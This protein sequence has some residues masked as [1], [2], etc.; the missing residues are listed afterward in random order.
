MNHNACVGQAVPFAPF[1]WVQRK[2]EAR[3][4]VVA[5]RPTCGEQKRAHGAGLANAIRVNR[6]GHILLV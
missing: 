1:T 6:R 4:E 5:E 2:P 3:R